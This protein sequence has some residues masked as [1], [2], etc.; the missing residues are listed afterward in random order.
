MKRFVILEEYQAKKVERELNGRLTRA[1]NSMYYRHE[2][3]TGF[4]MRNARTEAIAF[5]YVKDGKSSYDPR[6]IDVDR[7]I[8]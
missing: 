3:S 8:K 5:K 1:S 7:A 2:T 6:V 4:E